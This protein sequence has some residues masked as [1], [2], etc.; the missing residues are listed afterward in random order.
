LREHRFYHGN[1][2]ADGRVVIFFYFKDGDV[3][4]MMLMPGVRGQA[5]IARFRLNG[6]PDPREN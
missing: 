2:R 5:D 4:M 1:A 6:V 3:G